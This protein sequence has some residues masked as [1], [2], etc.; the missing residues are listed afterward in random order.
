MQLHQREQKLAQ[1]I[2]SKGIYQGS[3]CSCPCTTTGQLSH[4]WSSPDK[5]SGPEITV[6]HGARW[7]ASVNFSRRLLINVSWSW[8]QKGTAFRFC[9]FL[10][11]SFLA[12]SSLR[13]RDLHPSSG[14]E[15]I[16]YEVLYVT[17]VLRVGGC[18]Y[19]QVCLH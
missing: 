18:S 10:F 15:L 3:P 14:I 4:N 1:L 13:E 12:L 19:V 5:K 17:A 9:T 7:S 11:P 2:T 8:L 6:Q 16:I